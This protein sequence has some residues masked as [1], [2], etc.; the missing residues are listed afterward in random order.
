MKTYK[1]RSNEVQWASDDPTVPAGWKINQIKDAK[2]GVLSPA[3]LQFLH[4]GQAL[5]HMLKEGFPAEEAEE[6]RRCLEHEGWREHHALPEGWRIRDK[7][8]LGNGTQC[9]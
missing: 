8:S 5:R 1:P 2:F 9:G 4:R 6:M 7:A 3:G